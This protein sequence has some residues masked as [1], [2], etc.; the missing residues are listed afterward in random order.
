MA[1][2]TILDGN[3]IIMRSKDFF[4]HKEMKKKYEDKAYLNGHPLFVFGQKSNEFGPY[5]GQETGGGHKGIF[6]QILEGRFGQKIAQHNLY[7]I[8][9]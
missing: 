9:F 7:A 1:S 3:K 6:M 2:P 8:K 4:E 5:D